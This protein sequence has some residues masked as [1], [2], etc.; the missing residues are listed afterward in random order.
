MKI[1]RE[2]LTDEFLQD[3]FMKNPYSYHIDFLREFQISS[4]Q[5]FH[6][7][8]LYDVEKTLIIDNIFGQHQLTKC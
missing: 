8:N 2:V 5:T 4:N 7:L 1:I 3:F 6:V